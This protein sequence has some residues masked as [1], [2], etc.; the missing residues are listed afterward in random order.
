MPAHQF[1][2]HPQRGGASGFLQLF[3][4]PCQRFFPASK[5][6]GLLQQPAKV[7][8]RRDFIEY[9]LASSKDRFRIL[10]LPANLEQRLRKLHAVAARI[11]L[12]MPARRT[13][14]DAG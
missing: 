14:T 9:L 10:Q 4:G 3:A 1:G 11:I 5:N 2:L 12:N 7:R 13:V 8:V 6:I